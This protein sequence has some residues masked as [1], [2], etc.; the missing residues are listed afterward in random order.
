M[1]LRIDNGSVPGD[2]SAI[3]AAQGPARAA[4]ADAEAAATGM[5]RIGARILS[6]NG[7]T[8]DEIR[9]GAFTIGTVVTGLLQSLLVV[10]YNAAPTAR[11]EGQY[12]PVQGASNGSVTTTETAAPVYENNADGA[13]MTAEQAIA[14]I[15]G[16]WSRT[17]SVAAGNAVAGIVVKAGPGRVRRIRVSNS[18]ATVGF[19]FQV[20]D[21]TVAPTSTVTL[22]I[23]R[24]WVPPRDAVT[25]SNDNTRL[26]DYGPG[27]LYCANGIV[28]AA[29][30]TVDV[31][32]VLA[33]KDSNTMTQW[34]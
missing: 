18:N 21:A 10:R 2:T 27:G 33:T 17:S 24:V 16:A 8:W 26:L 30:S 25:A 23:D 28:I 19:Y 5:S 9:S 3:A 34:L 22:A 29:S 7:A 13:A 6:F 4:I 1:G 32:T 15:T 11:T 20:F 31:F 12:G 14:S